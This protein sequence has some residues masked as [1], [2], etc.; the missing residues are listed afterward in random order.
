MKLKALLFTA[1]NSAP[2][3]ALMSGG[4]SAVIEILG[5]YLAMLLVFMFTG[6]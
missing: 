2:F 6:L 4:L 5:Y 3:L 1:V